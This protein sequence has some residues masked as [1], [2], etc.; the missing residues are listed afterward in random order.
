MLQKKWA[1]H[2]SLP[3]TLREPCSHQSCLSR[4]YKISECLIIN[5]TEWRRW[6]QNVMW[7]TPHKKLKTRDGTPSIWWKHFGLNFLEF[8]VT[9]GT[10]LSR[11]SA[12]EDNLE[13]DSEIL[14]ISY[15]ELPFLL[16]FLLEFP[17]FFS[18]IVRL[19]EIEQFSDLLETFQWE[20][21]TTCR[22]FSKFSVKWKDP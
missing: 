4:Q 21:L 8:L 11:I 3:M 20:L 18:W 13:R 1:K 6:P 5:L 17:Q 19:S 12:I 22:P 7:S 14:K 15:L 16:P 10:A 2:T 9:R